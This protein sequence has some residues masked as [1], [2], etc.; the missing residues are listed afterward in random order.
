MA[1][2]TKTRKPEAL[3]KTPLESMMR[4]HLHALAVQNYS[5][6]TL[7]SPAVEGCCLRGCVKKLVRGF[8]KNDHES[9]QAKY[10]CYRCVNHHDPFRALIRTSA[11]S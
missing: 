7:R 11:S 4:D 2:V 5:A 6:E 3:P 9:E 8:W 1:R 10:P